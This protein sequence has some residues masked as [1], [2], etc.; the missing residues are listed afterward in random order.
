MNAQSLM[1]GTNAIAGS[2]VAELV[3]PVPAPEAATR[4]DS[5]TSASRRVIRLGMDPS[6]EVR[7]NIGPLAGYLFERRRLTWREALRTGLG[8]DR[9]DVHR[10]HPIEARKPVPH[11]APRPHERVDDRHQHPRD[12]VA[13]SGQKTQRVDH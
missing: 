2:L 10:A 12:P 1:R 13:E 3:G 11:Q 4:T 7:G 9:L 5:M 8:A 6:P